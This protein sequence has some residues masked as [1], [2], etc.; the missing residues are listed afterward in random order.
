M[1]YLFALL[2]AT[3]SFSAYAETVYERV[4]RTGEL[5][6]GYVPWPGFV[7]IDPNTGK[8]EGVTVDYI[9][10]IGKELDLKIIWAMETGWGN[11]AEGL[12]SNKYDVMCAGLWKSGQRAKISLLSRTLFYDNMFGFARADDIRFKNMPLENLNASDFTITVIDGDI[13]QA[14]RRADFP[15][16]KEHS[17]SADISAAQGVMSVVTKKSDIVFESIA[18]INKYNDNADIKLVPINN[19]KPIR[20]FPVCIGMKPGEHDLKA[21]LDASIE[22]LQ[23]SGDFKKILSKYPELALSMERQK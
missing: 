2:L 23:V 20:Q 4:M 1:K 7:E 8:K 15:N 21:M 13:T 11:Y 17:I 19:E 9:E 14:V 18:S 16:A 5:R 12:R 10:A 22:A 6:C 3:I